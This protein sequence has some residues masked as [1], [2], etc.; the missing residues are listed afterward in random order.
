MKKSKILSV[1]FIII[2]IILW[3][4]MSYAEQKSI[5]IPKGTT[6]EKL[7]SG[8]FKFKLPNGRI[9]E[10]KEFNP[11]TGIIGYVS[12]IDPEPPGKPIEGKKGQFIGLVRSKPLKIISGTE[13]LQIDNEIIWIKK[14]QKVPKS[15]YV[16][17]DDDIAWLPLEL[18]FQTEERE[19]K[20]LSPQADPPGILRK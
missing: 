13:Y 3:N 19:L 16:M 7:G 1:L 15:D 6:L 2:L 5:S 14:A 9:I 18:R 17:I 10:I 4:T 8:H 12:I 20:G 11:T